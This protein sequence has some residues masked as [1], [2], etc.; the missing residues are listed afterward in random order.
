MV[1]LHRREEDWGGPFGD[2]NAFNPERF[3][4]GAN[5]KLG[6]PPR[7]PSAF[8]PCECLSCWWA[9]GRG[10]ALRVVETEANLQSGGF[11]DRAAAWFEATPHAAAPAALSHPAGGFGVR[12]C[13][14]QLFA[15]WEA[16]CFLAMLIPRFKLRVPPGYVPNPSM[17]E[18]GATP[19]PSNLSFYVTMRHNAPLVSAPS[20][21]ADLAAPAAAAGAAPAAPAAAPAAGAAP[22]AA[23]HSTPLLVLFGSNS[24]MC[25]DFAQQVASKARAAGFAATTATLDSTVGAGGAPALPT[26]GAVAVISSTYNGAPPDNA[27]CFS[28]W[29]EAAAAGSAEGVKFAVFGVGNSQ[30]AATFQAFPKKIDSALAHAGAAQVLPLGTVDVDQAGVTDVFDEW[31]T[32]LVSVLL[33]TFQ[34][35]A[36][37]GGGGAAPAAAPRPRVTLEE[38]AAGAEVDLVIEEGPTVTLEA[39]NAMNR[40]AKRVGNVG[41]GYH[42]LEVLASRELLPPDGARHTR[43]VELALPEGLDYQ[44]GDHLEVGLT[45]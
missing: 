28:K 29:L 33:S 38:L 36:P 44:A 7:H 41:G 39:L 18:G 35:A 37:G 19:L 21:S 1:A 42:P 2:V 26:A 25:E 27:R 20:S 31:S 6:L 23:G 34:V 9:S 45:V 24:G 8:L 30:W 14:G 5:E 11:P 22:A 12:S 40:H 4:P 13:I 17:K 32:A 15:L 10:G 43:H 16:K 3:M